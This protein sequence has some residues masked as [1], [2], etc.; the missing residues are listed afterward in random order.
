[1][2]R[3]T[4]DQVR[5]LER[6]AKAERP[7]RQRWR[8]VAKPNATAARTEEQYQRQAR[9]RASQEE[10]AREL[11]RA[12]EAALARERDGQYY[13]EVEARVTARAGHREQR[14]DLRDCLV[15]S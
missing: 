5:E 3:L 7:P 13:R 10:Q 11:E 9:E 1:M 2:P 15:R 4:M 8:R 14:H 6:L 12:R